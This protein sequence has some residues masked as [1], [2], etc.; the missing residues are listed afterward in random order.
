MIKIWNFTLFFLFCLVV[1]LGF[2]IPLTHLLPW[3]KLPDT[4]QAILYSQAETLLSHR[5]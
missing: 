4:I 2:N 1:A 3:V 5:L